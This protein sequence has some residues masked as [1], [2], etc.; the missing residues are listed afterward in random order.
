MTLECKAPVLLPE[1]EAGRR[2]ERRKRER[3]HRLHGTHRVMMYTRAY[4]NNDLLFLGL[5]ADFYGRYL[6]LITSG[7]I[8]SRQT[9]LEINVLL[10]AAPLSLSLHIPNRERHAQREKERERNFFH[11]FEQL[12]R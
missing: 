5:F 9:T 3:E 4:A 11:R 10:G 8:A 2:R 6:I 7:F 12:R 1:Q